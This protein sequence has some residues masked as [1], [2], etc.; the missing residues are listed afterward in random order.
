MSIDLTKF[1]LYTPLG[2]TV[3]TKNLQTYS[4]Q[5]FYKNSDG[6]QTYFAPSY[7]DGITHTENSTY[8]RSELRETLLDGSVKQANWRLDSKSVHIIYQDFRVD[9]LAKSGK[10]IIGQVHGEKSEH[11]PLKIQITNNCIYLQLRRKFKGSEDKPAIIPNYQLGTR[12]QIE[13]WWYADGRLKV[14]VNTD[15]RWQ[16]VVTDI[17]PKDGYQFD[18]ESYNKAKDTFYYKVGMYSQNKIYPDDETQGCGKATYWDHEIRHLDS[19]PQYEP[20]QE[21]VIIPEPIDEYKAVQKRVDD[22]EDQYYKALKALQTSIKTELNIITT[23]MKV[24]TD[25]QLTAPIYTEIKVF[26]ADM[27]KGVTRSTE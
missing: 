13:L 19:V 9:E 25:K 3:T 12:I 11:P 17:L 16:Q 8:P 21:P 6:S 22:L 2:N 1:N 15:G 7:G 4:D 14:F 24:L 26:K 5:F 23:D 10:A 18:M 20:G 27:E